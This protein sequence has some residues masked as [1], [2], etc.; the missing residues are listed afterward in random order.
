MA[1]LEGKKLGRYELRQIVGRGGMA[2]VYLGYDPHF[3]RDIA[4]KVFK[5]QDEEMLKRFVREARLMASLRNIH[6]MPVYDTGEDRIDGLPYYYIV[7][8]MMSGGTLR[9]RIRRSSLTLT[10]ACHY[11]NSIADALDY[12]H[13]Q[14]IIHRDIKASNVLLDANGECYLSDFGI[15]HTSTDATQLTSTG[16]ILGT[17]D[18]VAPELFEPHHKA[19]VLSDLYSLGVLLFEMVT[20]Q[21]PFRG[22]TQIVVVAMHVSKPPPSPRMFVPNIPPQVERVMLRSLEK[23]PGRRY[24]SATELADAFC[25]AVSGRIT[26]DLEEP[27]GAAVWGE[28]DAAASTVRAEPIILPPPAV[29]PRMVRSAQAP[30]SPANYPYAPTPYQPQ[31]YPAQIPTIPPERKRGRIVA[32]LALLALLVVIVPIAY[33]ALAHPLGNTAPVSTSTT[34]A[35]ATT[36]PTANLTGTAKVNGATATAQAASKATAVTQARVTATAQAMQNATATAIVAPTATVQAQ[37]TATAGVVQTVTAGTPSYADTL[38]NANNPTT[39][40]AKWDNDKTHC[41]F[42]SDGYHVQQKAGALGV[43]KGC[44]ETGNTYTNMVVSVDMAIIGGQTGGVFFRVNNQALGGTYAGYLFEVNTQGKYKLSYSPDFS[45]SDTAL[46]DW[47]DSLALKV[48]TNVKNKLVVSANGAT[49]DFY[50][51]NVFLKEIPDTNYTSGNIAFLA[52][53]VSGGTDGDVVYT[54]LQVFAK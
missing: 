12:I 23:N 4:V 19:D 7:M 13:S 42:A 41:I 48:G 45:L 27:V 54:N 14:G 21:L 2:D 3:A 44:I 8:P 29:G 6:L 5:R 53:T 26:Q 28:E 40:N 25:Q 30:S 24:Q 15:A 20:G 17:V 50:V 18:Y 31:V 43:L 46:Q 22:D 9:A 16:D 33:I 32:V 51:N 34:V 1:D 52:T 10:E 11:L 39:L 38:T 47:T 49:L 35:H 37:V 36:A